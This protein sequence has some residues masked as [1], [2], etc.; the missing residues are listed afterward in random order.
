MPTL[1]VESLAS[2]ETLQ[3][4]ARTLV[5]SVLTGTHRGRQKGFSIDFSEHRDYSPGDDVR[6]IDW[7]L[8]AKRDRLYIRQFEDEH[9]LQAWLLL[10]V[11]G[12]MFYCSE[13]SPMSKLE[14]A[15][16]LAAA[17]SWISCY[18]RDQAG[19]HTF[20]SKDIEVHGPVY[21]NLGARQ[22]VDR[23]DELL[24][25]IP[26]RYGSSP[27]RIGSVEDEERLLGM[28]H[29]V[30]RVPPKSVVF[31]LSDGFG[32]LDQ[33]KR[34]LLRLNAMNC[35]VRFLHILDHAEFSFPFTGNVL[36]KGLEG[37]EY[38]TQ[39]QAIKNAY[40]QEFEGFLSDI[41]RICKQT[42]CE[43]WA[44][45]TMDAPDHLLRQTLH[46]RKR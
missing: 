15:A 18:Q 13:H 42:H 32:D 6:F 8:L 10:D 20:D 17:I 31:V 36:F 35:D 11:S 25:K 24:K 14:Y 12:S 37:G 28:S 43:Y 33:F 39:S 44:A 19:L 45:K 41:R 30:E 26:Q 22:L 23:L 34:L 9:Q 1:S 3:L 29:S 4:R 46:T 5:Q 16:T 7:K 27:Q 38:Q 40:V 21:G 2:L